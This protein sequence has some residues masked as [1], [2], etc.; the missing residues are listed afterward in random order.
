MSPATPPQPYALININVFTGEE[1]LH[2]HAIV[3]DNNQIVSVTP[4][5]A[6]PDG[7]TTIDGQGQLAC[8]GFIDLQL[9][10][11]GGVL[12]NTDIRYQ[13]LATMNRTNLRSG[14]TQFLPTLITSEASHMK[15]AVET[16]NSAS[17]AENDGILGLHLEGP[18][19]NAEKKGAHNQSHIREL[20]ES[21]L[22]YLLENQQ[23]IRLITLAPECNTTDVTDRLAQ[24]GMHVALGHTN[25]TYQQLAKHPNVTMATHLYNAM[26][27]LNSREP[28]AV[29]Y[30]LDNAL[31]AG[32]IV[33][34]IH[35][36]YVNV[37][38]AHRLLQEKLFLVTDAVTPAG[39]DM[40]EFDM[41]GT[42]AFVT[43]GRCHYQ[44]GTIAGAA[45]TMIEGVR[46]LVRHVGLPLDTALKMAS[47]YPAEAIGIDDRYGRLEAGY[48]ANIALLDDKLEVNA[49]I[50]MG[51]MK[52][53]SGD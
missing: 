48:F 6:L 1:T 51:E 17:Q 35:C 53:Q 34:G 50:Q 39:T 25:A 3:I 36:D 11:C 33:D 52:Y 4:M 23:H 30:V 40:T 9:N 44:D 29:G 27:P 19:I 49:T 41:A 32:I 20:D 45:I 18:F 13:T 31:H 37:R 24:A 8:P 42:P 46:N 43:D 5:E 38:L 2:H 16:L 12:F 26:S 28:G 21:T 22:A 14:T 15:K 7:L 10:G 47:R